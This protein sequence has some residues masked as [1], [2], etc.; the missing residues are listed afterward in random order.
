MTGSFRFADILGP[1]GSLLVVTLLSD[2]VTL[3]SFQ[4]IFEYAILQQHVE[5]L[6][7]EY[8]TGWTILSAIMSLT[9]TTCIVMVRIFFLQPNKKRKDMEMQLISFNFIAVIALCILLI[10]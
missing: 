6:D 8:W 5:N 10:L 7:M 4:T 2:I 9:N 1:Y 3:Y